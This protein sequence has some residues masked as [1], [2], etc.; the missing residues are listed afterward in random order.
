MPDNPSSKVWSQRLISFKFGV[1]YTAELRPK[2]LTFNIYRRYIV[3]NKRGRKIFR[4]VKLSL[5]AWILSHPTQFY[6]GTVHV[7]QIPPNDIL[8]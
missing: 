6:G 1:A 2:N 3:Q 7:N 5:R 4:L 8:I